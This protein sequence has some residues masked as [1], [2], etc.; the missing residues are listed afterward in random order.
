[1]AGQ[2]ARIAGRRLF[3]L[4]RRPR[5]SMRS[6]L[7]EALGGLK[8]PLMKV[9]QMMATIP[10]AL[11]AEYAAE[12]AQLQSQ[13]PPMGK[14]FVRR[15]MAAELG[16]DWQAPSRRFRSTPRRRPRS[17]R[18]TRPCSQDGRHGRLQ[19][20]VPE[21]RGGGGSRPPAAPADLRPLSRYDPTIDPDLIYEEIAARLREELDYAREA[22][23]MALYGDMLAGEPAVHVPEV[24]PELS[25]G[26]LLTM[27]WLEG[28]PLLTFKDRRPGDAQPPGAQHVPGLVPALLRLRRDPRRPA[29]RQLHGPPGRRHQ[30]A[31]LRLHPHLPALASS[32]A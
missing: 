19:A 24:V 5:R 13:A 8:G 2:A 32:R 30:P 14:P 20:P 9:A 23:H 12:L 1:M 31:G 15:R 18:S 28:E 16:P 7:R 25:T 29:S 17:A 3:G 26:R 21:H 22:R 11:P 4:S 10:D 27:S 6:E